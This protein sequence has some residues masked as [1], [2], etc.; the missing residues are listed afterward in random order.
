METMMNAKC[1]G[2]PLKSFFDRSQQKLLC[3]KSWNQYC[4]CYCELFDS[5]LGSALVPSILDQVYTM[6][7]ADYMLG[8]GKMPTQRLRCMSHG[9]GHKVRSS[10]FNLASIASHLAM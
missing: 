7:E 8:V 2:D 5:I 9:K 1:A 10:G 4:R 6:K 3:C